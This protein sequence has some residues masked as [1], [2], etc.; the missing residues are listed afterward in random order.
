MSEENVEIV[1]AAIDAYN[2]GDFDAVL[3]LTDPEG[4]LDW[5]RAVGPLHGVFRLDQLRRFWQQLEELWESIRIE[6][7]EGIDAG[8]HIV[9]TQ[10]AHQQGRDGIELRARITQVWTTRN[11]KIVRLCLYQDKQ[12]ALEAAGLSE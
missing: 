2:R 4:E 1:R 9:A 5:S 12:E 8:E 6:L 11:S 10:T 3:R 7:D